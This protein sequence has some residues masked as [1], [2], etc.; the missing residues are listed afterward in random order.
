[1]PDKTPALE[2]VSPGAASLP[3]MVHVKGGATQKEKALSA[4]EYAVP[5]TAGGNGE[6]KKETKHPCA[7]AGGVINVKP[8]ANAPNVAPKV[9][10]DPLLLPEWRRIT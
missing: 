2:S 1:V 4:C 10:M 6:G 3:D 5:R 9:R 7:A 8:N